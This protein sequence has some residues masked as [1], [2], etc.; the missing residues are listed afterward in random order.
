MSEAIEQEIAELKA[1]PKLTPGEKAKLKALEKKRKTAS[2]S[3]EN[4][5]TGNVFAIEKTTKISPLPI[6]FTS[7]DRARLAKTKDNILINHR[8]RAFERLGD[9]KH[10]NE[11][12]LVRAAC[13]LLDS[14][15]E[16]EIIEAIRIVTLNMHSGDV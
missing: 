2:Q 13:Y 4:K 3:E 10:V 14:H 9:L 7:V 12:K 6:R 15:S 8:E 11:T 1:K 16:E 5:T